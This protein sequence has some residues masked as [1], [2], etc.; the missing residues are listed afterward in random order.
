MDTARDLPFSHRP[1]APARRRAAV[2]PGRDGELA[3][4][5]E[6]YQRVA[7]RGGVELLLLSG[8]AGSGKSALAH[9]LR[10]PVQRA[11]GWFGAG[12]S[13]RG[14]LPYACLGQACGELVQR[15]L[16]ESRPGIAAWKVGLRAALGGNAQLMVMLVPAL[17]RLLGRPEAPPPLAPLAAQQRLRAAF[18]DLLGAFARPGQPLVLFLDDLQWAD[19][20]S[21][22][23]LRDLLGA[24]GPAALL[25]LGAYR[26]QPA[27][28]GAALARLTAAALRS[29]VPLTQID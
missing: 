8:G 18:R 16:S 2:P 7:G 20:A 11:H 3:A 17:E 14:G 19:P 6:A 27:P 23:L 13:E 15:V 9:S 22:A 5:R 26:P 10:Q 1:A 24:P 28:A 21:L 29:G 25:L 4:L 12:R